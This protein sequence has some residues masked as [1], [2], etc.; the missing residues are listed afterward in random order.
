MAS[1]PDLS[2]STT[3]RRELP[4]GLRW[5]L[6]GG[7]DLSDRAAGAEGAR[8]ARAALAADVGAPPE[9]LL[10]A[11]QV[12]GDG[13]VVARG[14]WDGPPPDA[15]ALVTDVPGL[16]LAVLVADCVPVLLAD[17]AAGVVGVAHAGRRGMDTGVVGAAV[18]LMGELGADAGRTRALL[19]PS[20][21][22][23][24]Y[25]VPA[26]MRDDVAG[27]HPVT[28]SRTWTGT[29]S[30][31]VAAGVLEQLAALGVAAEQ[32][33]GCTVED[34]SLGSVRRSGPDA[35]RWAGLVWKEASA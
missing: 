8:A 14:P 1:P 11:H 35:P 28:A 18:A 6:S 3:W 22:A 5:A 27:R 26:A 33:P 25:E 9:R 34:E 24:C 12:H 7:A 23:R 4:G 29:P 17:P 15:D 32:L 20:V 31:D 19:G 2:A 21:C 10:V 13:A 30:L 16:V